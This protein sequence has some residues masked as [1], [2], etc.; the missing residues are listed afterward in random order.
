MSGDGSAGTCTTVCKNELVALMVRLKAAEE[1]PDM[2][3]EVAATLSALGTRAEAA[4]RSLRGIV[5]GIYPALL[6]DFGVARALRAQAV[7]AS[8]KVR[9]IGSARRSS[10][11]AEAALYF[12]CLEAIQNAAKHA[13]RGAWVT[14]ALQQDHET[15]TARIEDN[16][17]GFD[18]D[19]IAEGVG[20]RNIRD[21]VSGPGSAVK[22][23][24]SPGQG[25]VLTI[26]LPWRPR[27]DPRCALTLP[28]AQEASNVADIGRRDRARD[29]S[30]LA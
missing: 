14:L 27:R 26:T 5:N 18:P 24:S 16:G 12:S 17:R 4:L 25:T 15:L 10:E 1:A 22:L 19:R 29:L 21:R 8:L 3:P 9:V 13:G 2:P 7:R 30:G 23:T 20:L 28:D 6:I 11:E